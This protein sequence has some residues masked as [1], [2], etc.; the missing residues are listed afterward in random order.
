MAAEPASLCPSA[1]NWGCRSCPPTVYGALVF[2][3][4][5]WQLLGLATAHVTP[6][7]SCELEPNGA[8]KIRVLP[9]SALMRG[10][11]E[12]LGLVDQGRGLVPEK[13]AYSMKSKEILRRLEVKMSS[14]QA[15]K[16]LF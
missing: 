12:K 10:G 3:G 15:E 13:W 5:L 4:G 9:N 2:T 14:S 6:G 8:C 11:G 16:A 7:N 1:A